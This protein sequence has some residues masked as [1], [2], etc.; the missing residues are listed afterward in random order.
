MALLKMAGGHADKSDALR[1][2]VA[3]CM[4]EAGRR[5]VAYPMAPTVTVGI[6]PGPGAGYTLH[7]TAVEK[8]RVDGLWYFEV[9]PAMER[10]SPRPSERVD[11]VDVPVVRDGV[12]LDETDFREVDS[13][14]KIVRTG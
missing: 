1:E 4:A 2:S 5:G 10:P 12:M 9:T 8:S 13:E 6:P 7:L 3:A 11:G 14:P